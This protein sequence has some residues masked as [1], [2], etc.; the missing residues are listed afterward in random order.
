MSKELKNELSQSEELGI[1]NEELKNNLRIDE[2]LEKIRNGGYDYPEDALTDDDKKF[3]DTEGYGINGYC[4]VYKVSIEL[5]KKFPNSYFYSDIYDE[6]IVG[7]DFRT[8]S[9]IYEFQLLGYQHTVHVEGHSG[10]FND[11]IECGGIVSNRMFRLT[12][13]ELNGKVPPS[14][15]V[16]NEDIKHWDHVRGYLFYEHIGGVLADGLL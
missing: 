9:I 2:I 1:E 8:G 6:S 5:R 15:I 11:R 7:V 3:L 12:P 4:N 14:V 16:T 10:G 13:E